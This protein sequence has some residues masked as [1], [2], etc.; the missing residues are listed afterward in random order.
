MRM[1]RSRFTTSVARAS[2]STS[3]LMMTSGLPLFATFSRSGMSFWM[4]EIFFSW[5]RMQ[6]SSS[7][8]SIELA[9][10]TK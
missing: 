4:F 2:P 7:T 8:A 5:T 9:S 3:S 6:G 1:P 10:V